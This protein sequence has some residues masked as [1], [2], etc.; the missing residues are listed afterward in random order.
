[1]DSAGVF[2][3]GWS[4]TALQRFCPAEFSRKRTIGST[5]DWFPSRRSVASHRGGLSMVL[6]GH[7]RSEISSGLNGRYLDDGSLSL[8]TNRAV[9]EGFLGRLTDVT[10][11]GIMTHSN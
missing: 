2:H 5:K 6:E 3:P 10:Y 4:L 11:I 7:C 8:D 9:S 1:M